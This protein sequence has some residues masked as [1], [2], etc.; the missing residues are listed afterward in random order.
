MTTW[1][2]SSVICHKVCFHEAFKCTFKRRLNQ[3]VDGNVTTFSRLHKKFLSAWRGFRL[4]FFFIVCKTS[5]NIRLSWLCDASMSCVP[6]VV[7]VILWLCTLHF[8]LFCL[9]RA[10]LLWLIPTWKKTRLF[11]GFW[12][13]TALRQNYYTWQGLILSRNHRTERWA[14]DLFPSY[15]SSKVWL[16]FAAMQMLSASVCFPVTSQ[17]HHYAVHR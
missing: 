6:H 3:K 14:F 1:W 12:L 8:L 10:V 13:S 11:C 7:I 4:F 15:K 2:S 5:A 9:V 17:K 16:K